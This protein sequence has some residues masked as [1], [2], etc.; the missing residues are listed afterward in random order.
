MEITV[1]PAG[2]KAPA[3]TVTFKLALATVPPPQRWPVQEDS[4]D[5]SLAQVTVRMSVTELSLGAAGHRLTV[6]KQPG[7]ARQAGVLFTAAV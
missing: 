1:P 4:P 3:A 5:G 6:A 2:Q 7:E